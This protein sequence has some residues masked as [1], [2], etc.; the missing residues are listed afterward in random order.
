MN[1][2]IFLNSL[3]IFFFI[4][5]LFKTNLTKNIISVYNLNE[6]DRLIRNYGYCGGESI[7]YL[8]YLKK[9]FNFESNP[10]IIN[11]IHTPPINWSIYNPNKYKKSDYLIILN[12]PGKI[13]EKELVYLKEN[14]YEIKDPYYLSTI[15]EYLLKISLENHKSPIKEINFYKN[16]DKGK[17]NLLKKIDYRAK[18]YVENYPIKLD[19]KEFNIG[20]NR[21]FVEIIANSKIQKTNKIKI[22]FQSIIDIETSKIINSKENC[23]LVK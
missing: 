11:F 18:N 16:S 14:F 13:F 20:E 5:L 15:S 9:K 8:K 23:Y 4:I 6:K 1:K 17:L 7:G 12:Y 2:K 21:L 19:I 22:T 3:I 10:K